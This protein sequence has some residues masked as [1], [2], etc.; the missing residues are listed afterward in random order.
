MSTPEVVLHPLALLSIT[1]SVT[2]NTLNSIKSEPCRSVGILL[3]VKTEDTVTVRTSFEIPEKD[4]LKLYK[5]GATLNSEVNK[6]YEILGWYAAMANAEPQQSD[7]DL[8]HEITNGDKNGLFLLLNVS[9]CY[10][11]S[12]DRIPITF[13]VLRNNMFIPCTYHI[14]SVDVERIGVNDMIT[15]GKATETSQKEKEGITHAI[16]TMKKKVDIIV[17]YLKAVDSGKIQADEKILAKIAQICSSIPVSDNKMFR[18]EFDKESKDAKL[19]V[20]FMQLIH[21]V[22]VVKNNTYLYS[23]VKKDYENK[24]RREEDRKRFMKDM[25]MLIPEFHKA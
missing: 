24:L 15:S 19:T 5:E 10:E 6:E 14:A 9:K 8:H 7:V 3:G 20:L 11:K 12:T 2:H 25:V 4:L 1:Q 21:T 17:N 18:N 16:D 22:T 13:S 23:I